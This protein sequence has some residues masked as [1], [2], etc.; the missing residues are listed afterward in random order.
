MGKARAQDTGGI[1]K[2]MSGDSGV[3]S[4]CSN[5]F[6]RDFSYHAWKTM[7]DVCIEGIE[8]H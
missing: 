3:C 5:V 1:Q 8:D 7:C 2:G 6:V 4:N